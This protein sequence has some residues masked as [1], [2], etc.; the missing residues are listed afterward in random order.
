M[1][2][3]TYVLTNLPIIACIAATALFVA[4]LTATAA[5]MRR[6]RNVDTSGWA[7]ARGTVTERREYERGGQARIAL[8]VVFSTWDGQKVWF[9]DELAAWQV[10]FDATVPVI[11]DPRDPLRAK[12][13]RRARGHGRLA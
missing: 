4:L 13:I 12:V 3:F 5:R 6:G 8:T 9:T 2:P 11:Y 7:P 10:E 1:N